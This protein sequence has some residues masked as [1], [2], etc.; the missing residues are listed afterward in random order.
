MIDTHSHLLPN[1][2]DGVRSFGESVEIISGMHEVGV[3]ELIITPHYVP[4][5]KWTSTRHNNL[6][7]IESL[8]RH[9][10][11]AGVNVKVYLGN[12]LYINPDIEEYLKKQTTSSMADSKYVLVELPMSGEFEGYEDILLM[13]K[14]D[15]YKPILA[16]PERYQ[17]SA[18]N[19][20][21]LRELAN[22]G[23]LFQCN[24]GSIVNQYGSKARRALKR[25][26]KEKLIWCFGTDI[27][28]RRDYAE[29]TK[30]QKKLAKY[31][32]AEELDE[33]LVKNPRKIIRSAIHK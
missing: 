20:D 28:H 7:L 24:L 14:R 15:G 19:I 25:L 6:L 33:L 27:H 23:I 4:E 18:K 9:L 12:E 21:H 3:T 17:T 13:L 11:K 10:D 5:S 29:I 8:Q 22:M 31:Y 30:A 32:T 2:D 16:H 1:I 26:A